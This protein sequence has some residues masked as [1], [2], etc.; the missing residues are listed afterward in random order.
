[1]NDWKFQNIH[2][3]LSFWTP[4]PE[5]ARQA[6]CT[7]LDAWVEDPLIT[8][9][10]FVIPRVM[11]RDWGYLSKHILEVTVLYPREL[12]YAL[13]YDSQIPLVVLY[14]PRYVRTLP[15]LDRVDQSADH[16]FYGQWHRQQADNVHG[17]L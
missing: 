4:S 15:M 17:L 14:I 3:Q 6:I 10:I 16:T 7:F 11:Q 8:A 13:Q 12:P 5:L 9:G 2:A 1:L